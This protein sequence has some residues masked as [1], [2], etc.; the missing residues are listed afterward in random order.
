[1]VKKLSKLTTLSRVGACVVLHPSDSD[2]QSE[3]WPSTAVARSLFSEYTTFSVIGM[4]N[5]EN[6]LTQRI[7]K[8][9]KKLK[10]LPVENHKI[11]LT[12]IMYQNL[13]REEPL[14]VRKE[15]LIELGELIDEMLKD[16][17]KMIEALD[18]QED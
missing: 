12:H 16:I 10:Q 4:M 7:T 18:K 13:G 3:T 15:D 11:E 9:I 17:D 5:Q 14:N 8:V 2:F 1:M 6:F